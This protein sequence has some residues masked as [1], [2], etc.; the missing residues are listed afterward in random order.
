MVDIGHKTDTERLAIAK[1]EVL[2]R[3]KTLELIRSGNLKKGNVFAAAELAG[4]MAAKRTANL[5]PMCHPI[6]LT[7]ICVE[8]DAADN[9][10]DEGCGVDITA[11]VRSTGK[12]GVEME[13]MVAVTVAALTVYDMAKSVEKSM[14]IVNV[15]LVEKRGGASGDVINQ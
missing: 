3:P 7:Y 5:V 12:T 13:A 14:R 6:L 11:T 4:V 2:M 15:R 8:L 10:G 9:L 1:G